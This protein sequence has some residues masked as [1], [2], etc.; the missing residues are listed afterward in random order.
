MSKTKIGKAVAWAQQRKKLAQKEIDWEDLATY[1]YLI[2][3]KYNP[4]STWVNFFSIIHNDAYILYLNIWQEKESLP[5][6][7]HNT[8]CWSDEDLGELDETLLLGTNTMW[9]FLLFL[10]YSSKFTEQT[11]QL[12]AQLKSDYSNVLPVLS[13]VS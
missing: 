10:R 9:S 12:K 5:S 11:L 3:Q 13:E 1:L 2:Q 8:L 7:F 6:E 4:E